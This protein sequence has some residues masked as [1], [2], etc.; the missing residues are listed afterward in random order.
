MFF[1]KRK[2]I[3]YAYHPPLTTGMTA[4]IVRFFRRIPVVYD[5]QDL[6][7]DTLLATNMIK[8]KFLY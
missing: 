6:W 2:D 7:P 1:M 4:V 3:I 5:I 8:R